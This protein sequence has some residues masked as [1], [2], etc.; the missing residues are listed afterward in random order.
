MV[1]GGRDEPR[2]VTVGGG[3]GGG[4]GKRSRP[5]RS[6]VA[7]WV[8]EGI[9][10]QE[11]EGEAAGRGWGFLRCDPGRPIRRIGARAEAK[12]KAT[13]RAGETAGRG[14]RGCGVAGS[15]AGASRGFAHH[16]GG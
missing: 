7:V 6:G 4:R 15:E 5:G 11:E 9:E 12:G 8:V 14:A 16:S 10:D 3:Q 13:D 1:C 2:R